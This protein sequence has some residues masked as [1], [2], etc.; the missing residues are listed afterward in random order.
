MA[1]S[2]DSAVAASPRKV[3]LVPLDPVHDVALKVL[4]RM[5]KARGHE[6]VLLPPDLPME[7]IVAKAAEEKPDVLM[8]SRTLSYG[9][10]ELLSRF[11]DQV[12]VA[13]LREKTRLVIGGKAIHPSLAAE[14]GFDAGFG[15]ESEYEEAISFVEGRTYVP[16]A[17]RD[18]K[19]KA[20]IT[21]GYRYGYRNAGIG[22]L[23]D[24]I[25]DE[26]LEWSA[27][28]T[29][30]GVR[31][32][33]LRKRMMS[34]GEASALL[35]EYLALCDEK[36]V[37]AYEKGEYPNKVRVLSAEEESR[38]DAFI[39]QSKKV[40]RSAVLR[41]TQKKPLVFVQYG[42]GCPIMDIQHIKTSE[43]WGADGVF[44]FDPSWGA[45]TE[46][47]LS[48]C[49]S[50]EE[51]GSV[52]TVENLRKIKS[53]LHPA[54]IWT[55]RA[56]RGLN[57]PE[58][59]V[60]AG[61]IGADLTKINIV[62]GSLNGGTDPERL[63]VDGVA[64]IRYAASYGMPFD[65][66]TNE[67]LGGVPA[68]KAFAGM[69]IVA[70]LAL[71]LGAKPILK[72]LFCYSPD[73]MVRGLMDDNYVDYNAAKVMALRDIVDAPIWPGEPIGFMTHSED[74]V[75]SAMATALHASLGISLGVDAITVASTD[76]AYS[77]GPIS[78]AARVDTLQAVKEAFRFF[79]HSRIEPT[80]KAREWADGLIKGI[81]TVLVEV[82]KRGSFVGALYDGLL[83]G[84]EDGAYPGRAGRGTVTTF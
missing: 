37:R 58:T 9:V 70:R 74:R 59:V 38:L 78:V 24:G 12:E 50:H 56:H 16:K 75:Q 47:F 51:D 8:V 35:P 79:G 6:T 68:D 83:G 23:L 54:T 14:L 34:E 62:Y 3:L 48:G 36:I 33:E 28:R 7:E 45:R 2:G 61:E 1:A 44:H 40:E 80:A 77:R 22:R 42:T 13:G 60:M 32:A 63:T 67:E 4:N 26:I 21:G 65:I 17:A 20:D 73:V 11:V 31:R 41:H 27:S 10:A 5:L 81:E 64:G 57:T 69:L 15:A 71:R 55:V 46:G 30:P 66:V 76:E 29:S 19:V 53:S 25:V 52:I 43:G 84:P 18:D 82:A 49:L 72:P 39:S